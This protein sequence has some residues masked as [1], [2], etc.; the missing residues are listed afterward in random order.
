M[1]LTTSKPAKYTETIGKRKFL[2]L[3]SRRQHEYLAVLALGALK[4]KDFQVFFKRYREM[5]SWVE[6]DRYI[7]PDWLSDEEAIHEYFMFHDSFS[8]NPISSH[9]DDG[10]GLPEQPLSW[11]PRFDVTVVL[12]QVRSPYN[13]GAVLRLIDNFGFRRLVHNSSWLR[14][15]HP[16]LCKAARG[17]EK[18]IP[19]EFK[20]DLVDWFQRV[21]LP[22]IGLENDVGSISI[23]EWQPVKSCVLVVGNEA[24]GI[25]TGLRQYCNP[26]IKIPMIGFKQSMNLHHALAIS[27]HKIVECYSQE[28]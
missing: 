17:S 1:R 12:D 18:W 26:L 14:L 5:Q 21:K 19:V 20:S 24:Y 27:A 11:Q 16:Q 22:I 23:E 13:A 9:S 7:P 3:S 15:D 2:K 10:S 25:A 28:K 8:N 6:L 4:H